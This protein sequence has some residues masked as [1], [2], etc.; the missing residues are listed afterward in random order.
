M[1]LSV[2]FVAVAFFWITG[3][4]QKEYPTGEAVFKGECVK[5]HRLNGIGGKKG[6]ELTDVFQKHDEFYIR[7]YV[8]DPRSIKPDGLMPPAE[9]TEQQLDMVLNYIKEKGRR[10]ATLNP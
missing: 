9:I 4:K 3:C 5:C 7:S 6:P 10:R 2:V 1:R 8:I